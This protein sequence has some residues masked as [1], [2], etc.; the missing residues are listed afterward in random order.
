MLYIK[1]DFIKK[2]SRMTWQ[3]NHPY[4]LSRNCSEINVSQQNLSLAENHGVVGVMYF[5]FIKG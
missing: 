1:K 5:L 4:I 3:N 2:N